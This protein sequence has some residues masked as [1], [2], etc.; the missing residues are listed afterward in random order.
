LYLQT[1][2]DEQRILTVLAKACC[3]AL[4][5]LLKANSK[6]NSKG[7]L[8]KSSLRVQMLLY[9]FCRFW[10]SCVLGAA[11]TEAATAEQAAARQLALQQ[12]Q[13]T[14]EALQLHCLL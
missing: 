7:A 14:G 8:L 6:D 11:A 9:S 13:E 2:F 5:L 4:Q 1:L 12:L 10:D 3:R